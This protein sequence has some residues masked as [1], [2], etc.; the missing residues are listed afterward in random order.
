MASL[1]ISALRF[2][3]P[4]LLAVLTFQGSQVIGNLDSLTKSMQAMQITFA[5]LSAKVDGTADHEARIRNLE[6]RLVVVEHEK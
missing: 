1:A 2:L 6:S 3:T 5:T 4:T